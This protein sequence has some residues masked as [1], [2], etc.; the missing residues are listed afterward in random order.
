MIEMNTRIYFEHPSFNYCNTVMPYD[1]I[2]FPELPKIPRQLRIY[3]ENMNKIYFL[4][5]KQKKGIW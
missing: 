5:G 2:R 1:R 4:I 3:F